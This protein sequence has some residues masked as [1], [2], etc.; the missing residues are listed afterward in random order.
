MK[1]PVRFRVASMIYIDINM[2]CQQY[3]YADINMNHTDTSMIYTHI[4]MASAVTS[5]IYAE[6][7]IDT[8]SSMTCSTSDC[9]RLLTYSNFYTNQLYK[10]PLFLVR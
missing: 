10:V 1:T 8:V 4:S 5:M 9:W 7:M 2:I 6:N 3:D